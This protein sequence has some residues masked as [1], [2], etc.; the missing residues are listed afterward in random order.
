MAR[1]FLKKPSLL[2][3]DEPTSALDRQTETEVLTALNH[4]MQN[5][6][7]LIATHR[8]ATI[9]H[10]DVIY[11]L[12]KGSI[13]EKGT[14]EE[15]LLNSELY[16]ALYQRQENERYEQQFELAEGMRI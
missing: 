12:D 4:L 6:T 1:I 2:I 16:S 3:L 10:A 11:V 9:T 13:V 14:H 7:T 15:L 5:R 8:I